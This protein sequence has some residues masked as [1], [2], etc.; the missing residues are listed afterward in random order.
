M[1]GARLGHT[2]ICPWLTV[3]HDGFIMNGL[4][5]QPGGE[6]PLAVACQSL[7]FS[8]AQLNTNLSA[9][10]VLHLIPEDCTF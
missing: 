1:S 2:G 5:L 10:T 3:A 4:A 6:V 8:G 9:A 7:L